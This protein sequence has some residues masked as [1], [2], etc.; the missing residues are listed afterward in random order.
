[1]RRHPPRAAI[2]VVVVVT[3]AVGVRMWV[4]SRNPAGGMAGLSSEDRA[5][6]EVRHAAP[7]PLRINPPLDRRAYVGV[8]SEGSHIGEPLNPDAEHSTTSSGVRHIG[9]IL[10]PDADVR[11][12]VDEEARHIGF[13]R[14][15]DDD[16][17]PPTN[18][19]PLHIGEPMEP[20]FPVAD[21][22]VSH[23]G[24]HIEPNP[25]K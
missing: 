16:W 25:D 1:M 8:D 19:H 11:S 14:D 5:N 6:V 24:E 7:Q 17:R 2:L 22:V 20:D 10:D 9:E 15:P 4:D 18:E 3:G 12:V 21:S 23:L 13:P